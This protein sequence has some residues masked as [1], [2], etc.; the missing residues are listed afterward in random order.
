MRRCPNGATQLIEILVTLILIIES[1]PSEVK[2]L[3]N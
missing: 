2:H 3:S 1:E